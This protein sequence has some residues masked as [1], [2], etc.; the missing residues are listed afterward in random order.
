MARLSDP[1]T[2][3]KITGGPYAGRT[4]VVQR[5]SGQRGADIEVVTSGGV[6]EV[7]ISDLERA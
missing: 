7:D 4:G 1:G 6:V 3:V 2:D 5:S